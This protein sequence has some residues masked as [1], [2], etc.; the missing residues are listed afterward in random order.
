MSNEELA[1]K[2]A[3]LEQR[4][5]EL[6]NPVQQ[7]N[8]PLDDTSKTIIQNNLPSFVRFISGTPTTNGSIEVSI[9]GQTYYIMTR[10]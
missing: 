6:E 5:Q 7:I 10:A 3:E 2:I 8:F 1:N 9:N 4:I